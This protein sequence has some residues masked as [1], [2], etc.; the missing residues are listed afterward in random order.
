MTPRSSTSAVGNRPS[1]VGR[2]L[3]LAGVLLSLV[4]GSAV[5]AQS[6]VNGELG[7]AMGDPFGASIVSFGSGLIVCL[8]GSLLL[9]AGRRGMAQ[10]PGLLRS[11]QIP[12]WYVLAGVGGAF[13]VAVQ[14]Q[15][16]PAMGVS[17]FILGLVVGQSVGGLVVDRIGLGPGGSKP[18]TLYRI[19][20]TLIIIASVFTAMSP[21]FEGGSADSST[22]VAMALLPVAAG[23]G[24]TIQ[25]AWNGG[26]TAQLRTP[27]T[28][29]TV[30]FMAG[31]VALLITIAVIRIVQGPLTWQWP[32][33]W[34]MYTGGVLGIVFIASA[35]VL[36]RRLGILQTSLGM[37][38]GN[39][40]SALLLDVV[41]PTSS[42][43]VTPLTVVGTLCTLVGLVVATLPWRKGLSTLRVGA[44]ST[45]RSPR[46]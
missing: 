9:P 46:R 23:V 16:T 7:V 45:A 37:V 25:T 38:T 14:T 42:S 32:R 26:I 40:L 18:L 43:V 8:L 39:L 28:A 22:M 41:L 24:S 1:N 11:R 3:L 20:G 21:R 5:A 44:T 30:N 35:A 27:I 19:I 15:V 12:W 29:T 6:R 36:A 13:L 34:W 4:A 10:L 33:T 2:L 17:V 31:T